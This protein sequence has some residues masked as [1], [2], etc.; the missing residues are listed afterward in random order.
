[1]V[2]RASSPTNSA[3]HPPHAERDGDGVGFGQC[4]EEPHGVSTELTASATSITVPSSSR[5]RRGCNVGEQQMFDQRLECPNILGR[6]PHAGRD[7][8]DETN[9][10]PVVLQLPFQCRGTSRR[11][12][13]DPTLNP[14][15]SRAASAAASSR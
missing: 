11:V 10:H 8:V 12:R 3:F 9:A 5:S 15:T 14:S 7:G 1:M 2:R 13:G 6:V 4:G